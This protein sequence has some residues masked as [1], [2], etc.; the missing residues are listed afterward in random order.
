MHLPVSLKVVRKSTFRRCAR[1][2]DLRLPA[3]LEGVGANAFEDCTGLRQ[4]H[5]PD[6]LR[7]L[8]ANAFYDCAGITSLALP[9]GLT[10]IPDGAFH[11]CTRIAAVCLPAALTQIGAPQGGGF[12]EEENGAF[13][14]CTSL[15]RVLA[16]D[17]LA[18]GEMAALAV[19][20]ADCPVLAAGPTPFSAVP[21][22]RRTLWHPTM[23]AWCSPGARECVL[24]V[25]VA[26]LRADLQHGPAAL[27]SLAHELWL[28]ILEFVP[29][30]QLG[31]P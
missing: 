8:G 13:G 2:A 26:E 15:A 27:P 19:V 11:G 3:G 28:L 9:P 22:L 6:G 30:H 10:S 31:S 7:S 25:L 16:P 14:G 29:R 21:R 1:I 4:V 20:F 17:R 12:D 5:L 18:R 23:H 24:A